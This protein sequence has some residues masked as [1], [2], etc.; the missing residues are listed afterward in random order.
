MGYEDELAQ[1]SVGYEDWNWFWI[2]WVVKTFVQDRA[3]CEDVNWLNIALLWRCEFIQDGQG[4][5][6]VNCFRIEWGNHV[7]LNV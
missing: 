5:E 3:D 6:Y 2:E 7:Y 4:S 1:D